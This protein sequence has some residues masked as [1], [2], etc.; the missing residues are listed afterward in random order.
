MG[1]KKGA[2]ITARKSRN[3]R[4]D[5]WKNQRGQRNDGQGNKILLIPIPSN[6]RH[7]GRAALLRRLDWRLRGS[8]AL[9]EREMFRFSVRIGVIPLTIMPLAILSENECHR[10]IVLQKEQTKCSLGL[11]FSGF[12][13]GNAQ[14]LQST[15]A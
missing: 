8:A 13:R 5:G 9:P 4:A 3:Q 1:H 12:L 2:G 10:W 15:S 6:N 11:A 14:S 7:N